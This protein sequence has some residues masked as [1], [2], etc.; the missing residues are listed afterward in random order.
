MAQHVERFQGWSDRYAGFRPGYPDTLLKTLSDLIIDEPP[1]PG[2]AVADIGSGTGI[3]TRQ[4]RTFLPVAIPIVGIEPAPDMR[5][6]AQTR[7]SVQVGIEYLDGTAENIPLGTESIRA[8]VAATAAHWFNRPAFYDEARRTLMPFGIMAIVEY[9]RDVETSPAAA[10]VV[11]FLEHYGGPRA[12]AP[13]DYAAELRTATAFLDFQ[14]SV[15][16]A[17][18]LLTPSEFLGLALSSSHARAAIQT[19][20]QKTA[21]KLLLRAVDR[22]ILAD[23][24]IP[25]GYRFRMFS[26][27]RGAVGSGS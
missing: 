4:L 12:Y 16:S 15:E 17:T 8:V 22:L 2:G 1:P 3:F 10:A 7:S 23:G 20:G 11:D 25:Y 26:A 6:E 19:L 21:E 24:R 5:R 9:V 18:L 14:Y 27:R 13:P